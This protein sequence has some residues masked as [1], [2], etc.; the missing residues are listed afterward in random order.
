[1][2]G[3]GPNQPLTIFIS[4]GELSGEMHGAHLVR[5]IQA[6]RAARG[7]SPAVISGNG[8]RQLADAGVELLFD[9]ATWGEM[10]ILA[11][12]LKAQLFLRAVSTTAKYILANAPDL[13]VLVDSRFMNL[14]LAKYL[15]KSGYSGK[16]A[17]YV[18]P[19]RWQSLYDPAENERSIRNRRFTDIRDYCDFAIPIYPIS[20]PVYEQLGIPHE[21]VGHPLCEL[22]RPR[23][24]D[25]EFSKLTGIDYGASEPPLLVGALPGS[26][27]GEIRQIAPEIFRALA[28]MK[29]AFRE[30]PALP[31]LNAVAVLAHE[32]LLDEVMAA[33]RRAQLPDLTLVD[34][35]AVYD[36]MARARLMIAKSGT[37][38]HECL[39]M[40]VPAIMCY[41][42]APLTAW[43]ARWLLRFKM[44]YYSLP[45]LLAS[46]PVV[47]ELIQEECN[48]RRIVELAG[49][50][51]FEERERQAMLDAFAE[52]REQICKPEPLRR[53]AQLLLKL[54]E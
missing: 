42:V 13:V 41:R 51:L 31:P 17:Y 52:L 45:N 50:L 53:A 15:R 32:D 16:I 22:A 11:N 54:V 20:L 2:A 44:P 1:V 43:L 37:G 26:R 21:Y 30:D 8:S 18:A 36:L 48:H 25:A 14:S 5:A 46:R 12:L 39:L 3:N 33:A 19:V 38:V 28:L 29:E 34:N 6:E 27:V 10:G 4:T 7:Q 24:S 9:V 35:S 49:T 23:L 47:P 40:N